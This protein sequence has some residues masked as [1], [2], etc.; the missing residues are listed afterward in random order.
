MSIAISMEQAVRLTRTF[1]NPKLSDHDRGGVK[2]ARLK[3]LNIEADSEHKTNELRDEAR[4]ICLIALNMVKNA[5]LSDVKEEGP[6]HKIS[7]D[8]IINVCEALTE[9]PKES[10]DK[11]S[12]IA[13]LIRSFVKGFKNRFMGRISS[14]KLYVEA[15]NYVDKRKKA[16]MERVAL[17]NSKTALKGKI[18]VSKK[19]VNRHIERYELLEARRRVLKKVNV[20]LAYIESGNRQQ[21]ICSESH[22]KRRI[23]MR[24]KGAKLL[25]EKK[26]D[27]TEMYTRYK[28][29]NI[30]SIKEI[31]REILDKNKKI[32]IYDDERLKVDGSKKTT[33]VH[34]FAKLN[35]LTRGEPKKLPTDE[36]CKE[37]YQK[38]KDELATAEAKV[39]SELEKLDG[40]EK[41]KPLTDEARRRW[42]ENIKDEL[43]IAEAKIDSELNKLA[44][45]KQEEPLTDDARRRSDKKITDELP[46][47]KSKVDSDIKT[48]DDK[49]NEAVEAVVSL[50]KQLEQ[51]TEKIDLFKE[52]Y[53]KELA[54]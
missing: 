35:N 40:S 32:L 23:N 22:N 30:K 34:Y 20:E 42:Y 11:M 14:K 45:S 37:S 41:D 13:K 48:V 43:S 1:S 33:K 50:R 27:D 19:E 51:T 5:K 39:D 52:L 31:V 6:T 29:E 10:T 24:L 25:D 53:F 16:E 46:I 21:V 7:E 47:A 49:M 28:A 2:Q 4:K 3:F 38:I 18:E 17:K 9:E 44:G 54:S 26:S 12:W 8:R 15:S 36:A